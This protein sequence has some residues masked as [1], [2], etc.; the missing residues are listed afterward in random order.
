MVFEPFWSETGV[1]LPLACQWVFYLQET[2]FF[3]VIICKVVALAK[4][5][6]KWKSFLISCGKILEACTNFR[7]LKWDNGE[8]Q[9]LDWNR[10]RV[11]RFG[12]H[13]STQKLWGVTSP[14]KSPTHRWF[15]QSIVRS[16]NRSVSKVGSSYDFKTL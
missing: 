3:R 2:N 4:C 14:G 5:L 6:C 10:V 9:I 12:S 15:G 13:T 11:S 16:F 8:T 7:D 1:C